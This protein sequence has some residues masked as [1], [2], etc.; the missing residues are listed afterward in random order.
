MPVKLVKASFI[1]FFKIPLMKG[2]R[3]MFHPHGK[4]A[5]AKN[6]IAKAK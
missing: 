1:P 5:F 6:K 4:N 3:G 2:A